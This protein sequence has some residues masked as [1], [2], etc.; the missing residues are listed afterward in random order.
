MLFFGKKLEDLDEQEFAKALEQSAALGNALFGKR[1]RRTKHTTSL[2]WSQKAVALAREAELRGF[3][4]SE[5]IGSL[6]MREKLAQDE[7]RDFK[8]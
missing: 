8:W 2:A 6:V 3:G 5:E 1:W 7:Y 4:A